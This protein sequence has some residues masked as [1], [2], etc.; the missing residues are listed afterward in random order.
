MK[1]LTF[2][3]TFILLLSGCRTSKTATTEIRTHDTAFVYRD[4]II[5]RLVKDSLSEREKTVIETKHDTINNVDTVFVTT[6]REK[7]RIIQKQDTAY[8]TK[9]VYR[10]KSDGVS[11]N[12]VIKKYYRNISLYIGIVFFIIALFSLIRKKK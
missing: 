9:Y 12:K 5:Y 2:V 7:F 1:W 8:I 4:S 6:E 10:S 11:K 3:F